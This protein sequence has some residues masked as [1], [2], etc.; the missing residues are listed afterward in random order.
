[1]CVLIDSNINQQP[2]FDAKLGYVTR[3][4]ERF[5]YTQARILPS[6]NIMVKA[7][8]TGLHVSLS[9]QNEAH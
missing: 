4:I 7:Q 2:G 6:L 3:R 9:I 8:V 5:L 1:M